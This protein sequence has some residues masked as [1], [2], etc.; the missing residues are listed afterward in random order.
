MSRRD[1]PTEA[2]R[3]AAARRKRLKA[4]YGRSYRRLAGVDR[5]RCFYCQGDCKRFKVAGFGVDHVPPLSKAADLKG[6][7]A[8]VAVPCCPACNTAAG[9][10]SDCCLVSRARLV[11]SRSADLVKRGRLDHA[12]RVQRIAERG[13]A[14][15]FRS[16]CQCR[17]CSSDI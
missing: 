5:R 4:A 7:V 8:F 12:E 3:A 6:L 9:A 1:P 13:R 15:V 11:W 17:A 10:A 14:G 2:K 16:A